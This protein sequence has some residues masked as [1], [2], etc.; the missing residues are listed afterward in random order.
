M[1]PPARPKAVENMFPWEREYFHGRTLASL[2]MMQLALRHMVQEDMQIP[3]V[4]LV[5][6]YVDDCFRDFSVNSIIDWADYK[7][8]ND[9]CHPAWDQWLG[10][11][12]KSWRQNLAMNTSELPTAGFAPILFWHTSQTGM[13]SAADC[14]GLSMPNYDWVFTDV[15][16]LL[17]IT[18]LHLDQ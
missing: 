17:K 13:D 15:S 4:T 5:N 10:T 6:K 2:L 18:C 11:N 12:S 7:A 9:S 14:H 8:M 3:N 16:L 1:A